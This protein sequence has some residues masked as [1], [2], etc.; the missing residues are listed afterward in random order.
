MSRP[1]FGP[2]TANRS[3]YSRSRRHTR[4]RCTAAM[5]HRW[6]RRGGRRHTET[7][8]GCGTAASWHGYQAIWCARA[9][10][11]AAKPRARAAAKATLSAV[12]GAAA[13]HSPS[14]AQANP[15]ETPAFPPPGRRAPLALLQPEIRR[16]SAFRPVDPCGAGARA[17]VAFQLGVHAGLYT[18]TSESR[19]A[20]RR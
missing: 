3:K 15:L 7:G 14:P 19:A 4:T 8:C 2:Y 9:R 1:S 5:R 18:A 10:L 6:H 20:P 13:N 16:A 17:L 12:V 11:P